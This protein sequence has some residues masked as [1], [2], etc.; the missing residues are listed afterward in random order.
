M[1]TPALETVKWFDLSSYS[2]TLM[3]MRGDQ[4]KS[5]LLAYGAVDAHAQALERLGM[6]PHP[7]TPGSWFRGF[8]AGQTLRA[9]D[10]AAAFPE[11][12]YVELPRGRVVVETLASQR[13]A[14]SEPAAISRAPAAQQRSEFGR[15]VARV[16]AQSGL[17]VSD[18]RA[19]MRLYGDVSQPAVRLQS[20]TADAALRLRIE[21]L[22]AGRT[23]MG[24]VVAQLDGAGQWHVSGASTWT[25]ASGYRDA[26]DTLGAMALM[27]ALVEAGLAS[28]APAFAADFV[29]VDET[30]S[31]DVVGRP[32]KLET[33]GGAVATAW[34]T[35]YSVAGGRQWL[36]VTFED[37]MG[38]P[39]LRVAAFERAPGRTVELCV[40]E[41]LQSAE[42]ALP[43]GAWRA[44]D[45]PAPR[46]VARSTTAWLQE[47]GNE[48][49]SPRASPART[50]T[51]RVDAGSAGPAGSGD[52]DGS[53]RPGRGD[54]E[55]GDGVADAGDAGLAGGSDESD[56]RE[57]AGVESARPD[58][59]V[60]GAVDAHGEADGGGA[61]ARPQQWSAVAG[62]DA[63]RRRRLGGPSSAPRG[64]DH[65][66]SAVPAEVSFNHARATEANMAALRALKRIEQ[67]PAGEDADPEDLAAV[68]R[69]IG[70]G[71]LPQVFARH[72]DLHRAFHDELQSLLS[73]SE[74]EAAKASTLNAHFTAYPVIDGIWQALQHL[75]VREGVGLEPGAGVGRFIGRR[76]EALSESVEFVAVE[77]DGVSARILK[78]LYP[79]AQVHAVGYERT[80]IPDGSVDFVVGNV[81]F[82]A[83]SVYD[84]RYKTLRAPIHDYFIVKSLDKLAPGGVMAVIT[85]TGTLDKQSPT[86]RE[87]MY[88]S[89]DLLG[90]FRMPGTTFRDNAGTDVTTD[91]LVF[92]KRLPD[93][94]AQP[95]DWRDLVSMKGADDSE[96]AVNR[97]FQGAKDGNSR[98]VVLGWLVSDRSQ[99]GRERVVATHRHPKSR[100]EAL[101]VGRWPEVYRKVL[102][103]GVHAPIDTPQE[104]PLLSPADMATNAAREGR[105]VVEDGRVC[106]I[107]EGQPV[108]LPGLSRL[109]ESRLRLMIPVRDTLRALVDEQLVGCSDERL[110]ELQARLNAAYDAFVGT[111]GPMSRPANRRPW[112][113][114][115]DAMLVLAAEVY[116]ADSNTATRAAIFSERTLGPRQAAATVESPTEAL[117]LCINELGRVDPARIEALSGKPWESVREALRGEIFFDPEIGRWDLAAR[118]L[119]GHIPRKL[120]IARSAAETDPSIAENVAALEARLPRRVVAEEIDVTL[121]SPWVGADYVQAFAQEVLGGIVPTVLHNPSIASWRV[122]GAKSGA[123]T[124]WSTQRMDA[125]RLLELALNGQSP[126]VWDSIEVKGSEVRVLNTEQTALAIEMQKQMKHEFAGW[127]F[128]DS[129][130]RAKLED[131]YNYL[132]NGY[133]SPDYSGLKLRVPGLALGMA[134]RDH[135]TTGIARGVLEQNTLLA[136]PV[137]F[138]KTA[139]IAGTVMLGRSLG[140]INKAGIVTPKN[141]IYQ[142]A[143]EIVRFF[144][145]ARVLTIRPEDLSRKGRAQF[146]RRVQVSNPD[147]ILVTPEA[148]KRLRLPAEA[149]RRY[150]AEELARIDM[151]LA[152]EA[153]VNGSKS[154]KSATREVKRLERLK[155]GMK[156][157]LERLLNL[158]EKDDNRISL[159]DLGVDAL[160]VDEAHRYKNLQVVSRERVLGVPTA[161]SQRASDMHSKVRYIQNMGGRV[162]FATGS[163]ITN[164]LAEAFNVQRYLMQDEMEAQGVGFFDAWKAQYAHV[165]GSLEPDPGG[166]GYRTVSRMAE[167][168]NVP[169]LVAMLAQVVDAVADDASKVGGRPDPVFVT[170]SV[171]PTE[172]QALYREALAERVTFMRQHPAEAK[173]AGDNILVVLGDARR[174]A[175]DLRA[176]FPHAPAAASGGK[177]AAV[178]ADIHE[179]YVASQ[180]RLG[181]QAVFLDF[182]TPPSSKKLDRGWNAYEEL[183]ARLVALGIPREEIGWAHDAKNDKAKAE[184]FQRVKRGELRVVI[185][186]TEKMGEGTNMQ[187][188]MV[189]IHH[190]N[191][192][193]HPGHIVQRNGR[194]IRFGNLNTSIAICTWVTKGLLEDWNWHLV[195]LKDGFIRQVT[196]GLAAHSDGQGLARRIVEDSAAMSFADIEAHASDNPLVKDK[197][198]IDERVQRLEMLERAD[199]QDRGAARSEL[200]F[201]ES[202]IASDMR[203]IELATDFAEQAKIHSEEA[204][205]AL[206]QE[207]RKGASERVERIYEGEVELAQADPQ[208]LAKAQAGR[209]ERYRLIE[210][211]TFAMRVRGVA[212]LGR[213]AAG[214][215][216]IREVERI[217]GKF[218]ARAPSVA[219]YKGAAINLVPTYAEPKIEMS[220]RGVAAKVTTETSADPV[221]IVRRIENLHAQIVRE[222]DELVARVASRREKMAEI[223]ARLDAPWGHRQELM[224]ARIEQSRINT[225]LAVM[226]EGQVKEP[227]GAALERF[228]QAFE[229]AGGVLPV[230]MEGAAPTAFDEFDFEA[231]SLAEDAAEE[232]EAEDEGSELG[233]AGETAACDT[234]EEDA[235]GAAEQVPRGKQIAMA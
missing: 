7:Q 17:V 205:A 32:F 37:D 33:S 64:S 120:D 98:G 221:G 97:I 119:S 92:R 61:G 94:V 77:Q 51:P 138:G 159:K 71:G 78:A 12:K 109:D 186:S 187:D 57:A 49:E 190:L 147:V 134:Y 106:C 47:T 234:D 68:S 162:V 8:G 206:L 55:L 135:Q 152:W 100:E 210:E 184:L 146:W 11:V 177:L 222:A 65:R 209:K 137:G 156:A 117:T 1:S 38:R 39:R 122:E 74:Y 19:E 67:R 2:L 192:P 93:D 79:A 9:Q 73:E 129:E 58:A 203:A 46:R 130:R 180:D 16:L 43:V 220:C 226:N 18:E 102:P 101:P 170:R 208:A 118:Y 85:S 225:E 141:V 219:E 24:S 166:S 5:W 227:H 194:G 174:S 176:Q 80:A 69:Y 36:D 182:A 35:A 121:G 148:F 189:A 48:L 164:T 153:E 70:W 124:R 110:A 196:E 231:F 108:A 105:Y 14:S 202:S 168:R 139:T 233:E 44:P 31:S 42:A 27:R 235:C 172:L 211:E 163:F 87:A 191:A 232:E 154:S 86:A 23:V 229:A 99:Y 127:I 41:A 160:C 95:F 26:A 111:H 183:T 4:G 125:W 15:M 116:D 60:R 188:R 104:Q 82:G 151:A 107:Y 223:Q 63:G 45:Q 72:S 224:D 22:G 158:D 150:L 173:K 133:R 213:V 96:I 195:T 207:A 193:H 145:N 167:L 143:A 6:R 136:H 81:P 40:A 185:G 52:A 59:D 56:L 30:I 75:G 204:E 88:A 76:P 84:P 165:V 178:A 181:T 53:R 21:R 197:A 91:L 66:L 25:G 128:R 144:P 216:L 126:Q 115:P 179:R 123:P 161:A 112:I 89:A 217:S 132:F 20:S 175:L 199:G 50:D 169:E 62:R 114:D 157:R 10:V 218:A 228:L 103:A 212:Q 34:V 3:L 131:R 198:V 54:R 142:F 171:E 201:L 140:I 29:E 215:A 13:T 83:Y 90:A 155:Q 230:A 28:Q 214:K 200:S 149:E 113:D